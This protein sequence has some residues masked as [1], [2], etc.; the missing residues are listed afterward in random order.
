VALLRRGGRLGADPAEPVSRSADRGDDYLLALAETE[1]AVLVSGDQHVLALADGLPI[2][3]P[4]AF[5]DA[6]AET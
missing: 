2:Q 1:R 3:T 5:L 6:L 4:R